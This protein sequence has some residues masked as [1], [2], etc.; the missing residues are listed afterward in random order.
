M[1]TKE[2]LQKALTEIE[3][4]MRQNNERIENFEDAN[5]TLGYISGIVEKINNT[6]NIYF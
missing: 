1:T 6:E 2:Q 3:F 5:Y 4:I